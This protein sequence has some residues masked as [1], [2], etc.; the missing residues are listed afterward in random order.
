MIFSFTQEPSRSTRYIC[1]VLK[2]LS[3]A[4]L[5][6]AAEKC[7][8]HTQSVKYL[9]FIITTNGCTQDPAKTAAI[10]E[11]E[12]YPFKD[13]K[14]VQKFQGY[15]NYYQL[16]SNVF[17]LVTDRDRVTDHSRSASYLSG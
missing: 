16:K 12:E 3:D 14:D 2:A 15:A 4:G 1:K 9:G 8:W 5:H 11:S 17:T 13:V 10:Q 6:L 7:K